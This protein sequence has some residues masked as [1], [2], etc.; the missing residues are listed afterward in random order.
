MNNKSNLGE[1]FKYNQMQYR[2]GPRTYALMLIN[3]D[4]IT[5]SKTNKELVKILKA[6]A[7]HI[8]YTAAKRRGEFKTQCL[9]NMTNRITYKEAIQAIADVAA[10]T[11]TINRIGIMHGTDGGVIR[12]AIMLVEKFGPKGFYRYG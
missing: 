12:R 4:W 2:L 10:G 9:K 3:N 5:S 7:K 1:S 11:Y 6:Q 8:E